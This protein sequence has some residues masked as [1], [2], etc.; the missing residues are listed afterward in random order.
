M[1]GHKERI[2]ESNLLI[3]YDDVL[4]L[5]IFIMLIQSENVCHATQGNFKKWGGNKRKKRTFLL[6][7][8][9]EQL[10]PKFVFCKE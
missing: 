1:S 6:M 8:L 4:S 9:P 5:L 2:K 3:F 10:A 7:S